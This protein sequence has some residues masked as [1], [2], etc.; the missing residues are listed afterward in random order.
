MSGELVLVSGASGYIASWIC[1]KL[2]EQGFRVR[3]TVRSLNN[4]K[5]VEYLRNLCP[6]AKYPLELVEADLLNPEGWPAAVKDCKYVMH[7]ASPFVF[8]KPK[9]PDDLIKP[10][11]EGT[12]NVLRAASEAG[13]VERVVLTSSYAAVVESGRT[14]G[15]FTDED[16]S[17][18]EN[19]NN[20]YMRSKTLAEKAAWDFVKDL[21][22]GKKLEL[23]TIMPSA[24]FGP[25]LSDNSS[26]S[27]DTIAGMFEGKVPM[28]PKLTMNAVDVRDVSEAHVKCITIPDAAG[29]DDSDDSDDDDDD[30]DE[31]EEEEEEEDGDTADYDDIGDDDDDDDDNDDDDDDD[32][33]DDDDSYDGHMIIL[34]V[35][36]LFWTVANVITQMLC[37]SWPKNSDLKN[38]DYDDA[39]G[40]DDDD[41]DEDDDDNY[42][43]DGDDDYEGDDDGDDNDADNNNNQT[44]PRLRNLLGIEPI[45]L[46]KT[47]HDMVY[48]LIEVGRMKKTDQYRGP[49]QN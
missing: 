18:P 27:I 9:H 7:T 31:E 4:A 14:E 36:G 43:V 24:V 19:Q 10:A 38:G 45:P 47:L 23:C 32:N 1:K 48:T 6:D 13:T 37:R 42:D 41:D 30:D 40:G 25:P 33:D 46:K 29:H 3:G 22:D 44:H 49:P 20:I 2:Q 34:Q 26:E 21:P 35:N 8:G 12:L 5:K 16:W 17:I 15:A 11:V 28:I 39:G